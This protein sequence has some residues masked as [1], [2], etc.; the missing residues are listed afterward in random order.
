[1]G[2][3]FRNSDSLDKVTANL[4]KDCCTFFAYKPLET[5]H[6]LVFQLFAPNAV[7]KE[8][9]TSKIQMKKTPYHFAYARTPKIRT[10]P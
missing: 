6:T 8:W 3:L 7:K 1:M 10:Y 9:L 4:P 2:G 5:R